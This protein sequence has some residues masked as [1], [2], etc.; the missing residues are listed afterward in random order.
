M[1]KQRALFVRIDNTDG[2]EIPFGDASLSRRGDALKVRDNS[3]LFPHRVACEG[4]RPTVHNTDSIVV[5]TDDK[6]PFFDLDLRDGLLAPGAAVERDRSSEIEVLLSL[7]EFAIVNVFLPRSDDRVAMGTLSSSGG[8]GVNLSGDEASPDVDIVI[9]SDQA[10]IVSGG[11]GDDILAAWGGSE[12]VAAVPK[13]AFFDGGY[14][15]D[16]LVGSDGTDYLR[17]GRGRDRLD[18]G[19]GRDLVD[20]RDRDIDSGTCGAGTGRLDREA[21]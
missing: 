21:A 1:A 4:R 19:A 2:N 16:W 15:D 7:G 18:S 10:P 5:G 6:N 9:Y 3:P 12:F 8:V 20:A 11:R 17:G 13:L 14:G